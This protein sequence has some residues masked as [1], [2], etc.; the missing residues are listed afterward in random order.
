MLIIS[1][2]DQF[3]LLTHDHHKLILCGLVVTMEQ[4]KWI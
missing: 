2:F 4:K 1:A 3:Q